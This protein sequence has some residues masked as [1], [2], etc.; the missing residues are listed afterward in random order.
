MPLPLSLAAHFD[1]MTLTEDIV[2]IS[3]RTWKN[4]IGTDLQVSSLLVSFHNTRRYYVG[5][6]WKKVSS[7]ITQP[8][9]MTGIVRNYYGYNSDTTIVKV[10]HFILIGFK[11]L[12]Q[13]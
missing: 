7:S 1:N 5:C 3:H 4:Q 10:T 8:M 12:K 9:L 13:V 6:T 11:E 2:Y